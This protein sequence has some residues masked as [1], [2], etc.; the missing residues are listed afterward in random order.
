MSALENALAWQAAGHYVLPGLKGQKSSYVHY[1]RDGLDRPSADQVREWFASR[2]AA[3]VLVVPGRATTPL[4]VVDVDVKADGTNGFDSMEAHRLEGVDR[5][6]GQSSR[7]GNGEHHW[8]QADSSIGPN[9]S[10]GNVVAGVDVRSHNGLVSVTHYPDVIR[11]ADVTDAA[12]SWAVKP[13]GGTT[14][15]VTRGLDII[16]TLKD[17]R[18]PGKPSSE[19]QAAG[20]AILADGQGHE[21]VKGPLKRL[22]MAVL[23]GQPGALKVYK[24]ARERWGSHPEAD[25]EV[26]WDSHVRGVIVKALKA[27][28]MDPDYL[29]TRAERLKARAKIEADL[30]EFEDG[31]DEE[32]AEGL[33]TAEMEHRRRVAEERERRAIRREA[34]RLDALEAG[35]GTPSILDAFMTLEDLGNMPE[36]EPLVGT[37]IGRGQTAMIV[38]ESNTGK[39][40][41]TVA[42]AHAVAT[43]VPF[44]GHPIHQGRVLFVVGEDEN[45]MRSR[46]AAVQTARGAIDLDM[47]DLVRVPFNLND[48]RAVAAIEE[49]V[50]EREY[51]LIVLDPLARFIVDM[52]E[53][54]PTGMGVAMATLD[55]LRRA[56]DQASI[57]VAH[58]TN[59]GGGYR[60][61]TSIY[62]AMDTVVGMKKAGGAIALTLD[63]SKSSATGDIGTYQLV[64]VPGTGSVILDKVHATQAREVLETVP[65]GKKDEVLQMF[66]RHWPS[67]TQASRA[68]VQAMAVD[69]QVAS[70][71]TVNRAIGEFVKSGH[72]EYVNGGKNIRLTDKGRY[73]VEAVTEPLNP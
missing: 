61:A 70:K 50:R 45:G 65:D 38:A 34:D 32:D 4:L 71:S 9:G 27:A 20:D 17:Y 54:D 14:D 33:T 24:A 39:T 31:L 22:V 51:A 72:L 57:V 42:M 55:R 62:A 37:L 18:E 64:N 25:L 53:N 69:L 12:P 40:F 35:A 15:G 52:D 23:E 19:A 59:K 21:A 6:A 49:K 26:S 67:T 8:Y 16:A 60:G 10:P 7:S 5:G 28:P 46:V 30:E 44:A 43:G 3:E 1:V 48:E 13:Y 11:P 66:A 47:F 58:H 41:L 68:E 63:K 36:P 29:P 56:N 2:E 73:Y